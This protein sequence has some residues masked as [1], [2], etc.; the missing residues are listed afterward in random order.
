M[1]VTADRIGRVRRVD[2]RSGEKRHE[3]RG[4]AMTARRKLTALSVLPVMIAVGQGIA[5]AAPGQPGLAVPGEGQPGLSQTPQAPAAPSP[6]DWI[7]DPPAP[8][9]RPRPQQQTQPN[10]DTWVQPPTQQREQAEPELNEPAEP[11][12]DAPAVI[13]ADPHQLRLGTGEV[14]LPDW[15]DVKTRDKAQAYADYA[16]WQIAAAYDSL[17]FSREESDRMAATSS[18]GALV[19]AGAAGALAPAV[20]VPVGCG[21]GAVVGAVAGG[22]IAGV[23]TA[24]V[25]APAGAIVG[26]IAG[27]I[28]GGSLGGMASV[29]LVVGGGAL[30][31]LAGGALS[32]GDSNK[33]QPAVPSLVSAPVEEAAPAPAPAWE[34]APTPVAA[35]QYAEPIAAVTTQVSTTVEAVADSGPVGNAVVTNLRDA[36]AAM[37]PMAPELGPAADVINGVLGAIQ[38][39]H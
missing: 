27:C 31:A 29:P 1:L 39:P 25:G 18:L 17:G 24:G 2:V 13:P 26:G 37:P 5:G 14:T 22:V 7:P 35:P 12:V 16:E 23:P 4:S 28:G 3:Y 36:A 6:A 21:I 10:I 32:G 15:V 34:P 9:A 30:A 8:P 11:A 20:F 19:G 38:A 33:P